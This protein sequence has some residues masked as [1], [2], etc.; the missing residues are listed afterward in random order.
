MPPSF[1]LGALMVWQPLVWQLL[2]VGALALSVAAWLVGPPLWAAWRRA[3]VTAA[4]FPKAWRTILRR[5]MPLYRR[6]PAPVQLQLQHH[7][8]VLLAD[9]PFIGCQGQPITDEVR[10]LVAA[11]A[12]LLLLGRPAG[13]FRQLRQVLVYPGP[14]PSNGH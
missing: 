4:P 11:Q 6:L 9:V 14:S 8:Q 3:R 5:R 7:V 2:F 13:S 1:T 10:V 12:S